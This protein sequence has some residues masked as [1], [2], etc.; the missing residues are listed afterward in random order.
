[1][2][3]ADDTLAST[4]QT[5]R[6][7]TPKQPMFQ[8]WRHRTLRCAMPIT[9]DAFKPSC[10]SIPPDDSGLYNGKASGVEFR[11]SLHLTSYDSSSH[12]RPPVPRVN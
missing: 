7:A 3:V 9:V 1:M 11:L 5:F 2:R 10:Q 12:N 6:S 8:L 4:F